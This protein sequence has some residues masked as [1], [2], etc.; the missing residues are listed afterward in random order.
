MM[1]SSSNAIAEGVPP[2]VPSA[3]DLNA[4]DGSVTATTAAVESV[5]TEPAAGGGG[6]DGGGGGSGEAEGQ[7]MQSLLL[8]LEIERRQRHD[9][10]EARRVIEEERSVAQT[11]LARIEAEAARLRAML[12]ATDEGAVAIRGL[13]PSPSP[14]A[15]GVPLA[16]AALLGGAGGAAAEV[17]VAQCFLDRSVCELR[18]MLSQ[19]GGTHVTDLL[20]LRPAPARSVLERE[21][22]R[23]AAQG[24][25]E[26]RWVR[27][28]AAKRCMLCSEEFGL[29]RRRH[30]CRCCGWIA[31][32]ECCSGSVDAGGLEQWFGDD[33]TVVMPSVPG[34]AD[35]DYVVACAS[36]E[37]VVGRGTTGGQ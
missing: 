10:E 17:I 29:R 7:T 26:P 36:C 6:G 27:D 37:E 20:A 25:T 31:C 3:L 33:G 9:A 22:S 8:Q 21:I 32:A 1:A 34:A 15:E 2:P 30:H 28:G 16:A 4:G 11:H 12:M 35:G 13:S 23:F 14:A 5:P 19:L 24:R 18:Q